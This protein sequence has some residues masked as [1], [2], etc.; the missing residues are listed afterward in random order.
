MAK[1]N[2]ISITKY[3]F[4]DMESGTINL[5]LW[6]VTMISMHIEIILSILGNHAVHS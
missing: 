5:L 3:V 1:L 6:S 2:I 4:P